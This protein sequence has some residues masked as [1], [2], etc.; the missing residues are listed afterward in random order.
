MSATKKPIIETP[1]ITVTAKIIFETLYGEKKET[2]DSEELHSEE[3][4][5]SGSRKPHGEEKEVST[6]EKAQDGKKEESLAKKLYGE[7]KEMNV[8]EKLQVLYRTD[9]LCDVYGCQDIKADMG[10][11]DGGY[12]TVGHFF[13]G[14]N[15]KR[16][17]S[18]FIKRIEEAPTPEEAFSE[19]VQ[20]HKAY[21]HSVYIG[22][23][24]KND[25]E[26]ATGELVK[27]CKAL[28]ED[29]VK[30][31]DSGVADLLSSV[32]DKHPFY[33]MA[34]L[35]ISAM[36]QVDFEKDDKIK[37]HIS[38]YAENSLREDS[39][40][41][42][43]E[44]YNDGRYFHQQILRKG[45]GKE[46]F[47]TRKASYRYDGR[48]VTE[49][50]P[51]ILIEDNGG[52]GKTVLSRGVYEIFASAGARE[53]SHVFRI[54]MV[55][56][57]G[58]TDTSAGKE[59]RDDISYYNFSE[60][61]KKNYGKDIEKLMP[62]ITTPMLLILDGFD[63]LAMTGE[64]AEVT[65]ICN[66]I[67]SL[68]ELK[69]DNKDK[70]A[71]YIMIFSKPLKSIKK[72][73]F[74]LFENR[75]GHKGFEKCYV[76]ETP[77]E[78]KE[79]YVREK[80]DG[81]LSDDDKYKVERGSTL[82]DL[83]SYPLYFGMIKRL[84]ENECPIPKTRYKVLDITYNCGLRQA[85]EKVGG[86]PDNYYYT[87]YFILLPLLGAM[88]DYKKALDEAE[89]KEKLK[90][91][92]EKIEKNRI[93]YDE[94]FKNEYKEY[95]DGYKNTLSISD[96]NIAPS[97]E[98]DSI[99]WLSY[100]C[101]EGLVVK[102][103]SGLY[104]FSHGD[105]HSF[106]K[107]KYLACQMKYL[108]D[109]CHSDK[110]DGRHS[111]ESAALSMDFNLPDESKKLL[112]EYE[113]IGL[114]D[115]TDDKAVIEQI[116]D[117]VKKHYNYSKTSAN[118]IGGAVCAIKRN[119]FLCKLVDMF[120]PRLYERDGSAS[121]MGEY[122]FKSIEMMCNMLKQLYDDKEPVPEVIKDCRNEVL[123]VLRKNIQLCRYMKK[124]KTGIAYV[125]VCYWLLDSDNDAKEIATLENQHAKL[126]LYYAQSLYL[127]HPI[128]ENEY[129]EADGFETAKDFFDEGYKLLQKNA[130]E[131]N[132][133]MS[134]NLCAFLLSTPAPFLVENKTIE[135]GTDYENAFRYYY[136][137]IYSRHDYKGNE[138]VYSVTSAIR[139][140][141]FGYVSVELETV[142]PL[143]SSA[144]KIKVES[145]PGFEGRFI[146]NLSKSRK[147]VDMLLKR[148]QNYSLEMLDF[149]RDYYRFVV[150][151]EDD[152]KTADMSNKKVSKPF[153][154]LCNI[155]KA[156]CPETDELLKSFYEAIKADGKGILDIDHMIHRYLDFK[157]LIKRKCKYAAYSKGKTD[158]ILA[159][160]K[161]VEDDYFK[162]DKKTL[163]LIRLMEGISTTDKKE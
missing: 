129:I 35:L 163:N 25:V 57:A 78:E 3:K 114:A 137:S 80:I 133:N 52:M 125:K 156:D 79:K 69:L 61:I 24:N 112:K 95:F 158:G 67:K 49:N 55:S 142:N 152:I 151:S 30:P 70:A 84:K 98:T 39:A 60:V 161:K 13:N 121:E 138:I 81:K 66:E 131:N 85:S 127:G 40:T 111:R 83:L 75:K 123:T 159:H 73:N 108:E 82:Y 147:V 43:C 106:L 141:V 136:N 68:S 135:G 148:A 109:I 8:A 46:I 128:D 20:M 64:D 62:D 162:D 29:Y 18:G 87:M 26:N 1:P 2:N 23:V 104:E 102:N 27:K 101:T 28:V 56:L 65:C 116:K 21:F 54:S 10:S 94:I 157:F 120:G 51:H 149:Y 59:N 140:I 86:I 153:Y 72:G 88:I 119:N 48:T 32:S 7:E 93:Y 113:Y 34:I 38:E 76:S 143:S 14:S 154:A 36:I 4:G 5:T 99:D 6:T 17:K 105:W 132:S 74:E 45:D 58:R 145:A 122:L 90:Q 44:Y 100:I 126:Y 9:V 103:D 12:R 96:R 92:V 22:K 130:K 53:F 139:L 97:I 50:P 37:S 77:E 42:V 41:S 33:A 15:F 31:C 89:M 107:V 47:S 144:P 117:I 134:G 63:E 146:G 71:V 91:A 16:R 110:T 115:K 118:T 155:Q 19:M 150:K 160:I 124:Y 11:D